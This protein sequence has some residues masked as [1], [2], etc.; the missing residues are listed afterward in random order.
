MLKRLAWLG[1]AACLLGSASPQA[2]K[3]FSLA[4]PGAA[5]PAG[6]ALVA[7]PG[8]QPPEV[9]LVE[10]AGGTVLRL[11]A[12]RAAGSVAHPLSADASDTPVLRWRWKVDR[13]VAGA[14]LARKEGD[15]Y[16]ARVY[17]TFD[18]PEE[19]LS[20]G[21]RAR[22][23]LG[24][25]LYGADVPAAALCY[26]W[27]NKHPVGTSAWNA[28]SSRVRMV[29]VASGGKQAGTWLSHSRDVAADYRAAFGA[30]GP[31]PPISGVAVSA[32]TDQ[33]GE[34]VTAW[35]GDL[36]LASR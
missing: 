28:Y 9:A 6:W 19:D 27:D 18:V 30:T 14:D 5:L 17:V 10:D 25:L 21:E 11:R 22:S 26:V 3:P 16:A 24:R 29:V 33:T 8:V 23:A 4:A 36:G 34:A 12:A 31:V 13:V 32:D 2:I 1:A 20:L 35:F 7:L 15:D